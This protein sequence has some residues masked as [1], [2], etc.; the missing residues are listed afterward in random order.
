MMPKPAD[1]TPGQ[2]RRI[3]QELKSLQEQYDLLS[4]KLKHL[5]VHLAIQAG[6]AVKFQLEKEKERIE[7]EIEQLAQQIE[8]LENKLQ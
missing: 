8:E 1:L 6:G 4:E 2:R 3:L 7:N 5:R